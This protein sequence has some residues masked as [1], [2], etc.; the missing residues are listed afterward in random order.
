MFSRVLEQLFVFLVL[1]SSMNVIT[2][3]TKP[4]REQT[5]LKVVSADVNMSN[6]AI[7]GG[8]YIY[9]ALLALMR[10]RRVLRAARTVWP[11]LA[12]AALA[13]L[14]TAWSVQPIVTLRRSTSLLAG[15]MIAI[16]LGE[17]Y[18][19]KAFARL[20]AYTLCF[21]TIVVVVLY[22]VA[23]AYV[24]DYSAY[25]GAW[26]GLSVYKN[27]FGQH[28]AVAVA[29]L[30]LVRF[31]RLCSLR[32]VFLLTAVGLLV[33]SR[34]AAALV[35]CVL[36]LAAMPL[37]RTMRGEQR[38]LVYPLATLTFLVGIYCI[39]ANPE[40]LFQ[41]LGRDATLTGRTHLWAILL[42]AIA[43]HPILGY[44]YSAFWI[45]LKGEALDV[46]VRVGWM[47]PIAD[48]GYIDLCLSLG[49]L[50]VCAFLYVFV[51][52][53]RRAI[54]YV[55]LDPG[56]IGLWPV[57][58]LCLFAVNNLCESA[59]LTRATF[60]FLMFAVL[61][62]SLAMNHRRVVTPARTADNQLLMREWTTPVISR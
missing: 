41:I 26:K 53:F 17:R 15:I 36:S 54:D 37:W 45:G 16:Y 28:M 5:E 48:N 34:S 12:L 8:V 13:F 43:K 10:W 23:P 2:A 58:Y 44:G 4:P 14:S 56:P 9:G 25:A 40:P 19:I 33:L 31:H 21:M 49:G 52:S 51:S 39:V 6:V 57:T 30:V 59:L 24:V 47:A 38:L 3:L 11:L 7:E 27:T 42:P 35:C 32:Y 29:L 1:L 62:T 50:G 18:S 22:C 61:T 60:P 46:W 20:L 55:R